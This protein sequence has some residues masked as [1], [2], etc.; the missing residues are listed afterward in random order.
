MRYAHVTMELPDR[1]SVLDIDWLMRTQAAQTGQTLRNVVG[2]AADV[3]GGPVT[4]IAEALHDL[5]WQ[6][7][8]M[9]QWIDLRH[10]LAHALA[11]G[12]WGPAPTGDRT[13]HSCSQWLFPV[14]REFARRQGRHENGADERKITCVAPPL[15]DLATLR[16]APPVDR[17]WVSPHYDIWGCG[18]SPD[19]RY[20]VSGSRGGQGGHLIVWDAEHGTKTAHVL[21]ADEVR[22]CAVT[23]D[24]RYVISQNCRGN[25]S[26][27]TLPALTL[28]GTIEQR[29]EQADPDEELAYKPGHARGSPRRWRR[30]AISPDARQLA[31]AMR[32]H[33]RIYTL[34]PFEMTASVNDLW[35]FPHGIVALGFVG[36][37][38][39]VIVGRNEP[40]PVR[41]CDVKSGRVVERR[42]FEVPPIEGITRAIVL[43]EQRLV[44]AGG[45]RAMVVWRLD[46]ASPVAMTP[47]PIAGQG[48]A[49]SADGTM[50]A[51]S[52]AVEYE[53][54][55]VSNLRDEWIRLWS[56]PDLREL[57][58]WRVADLGCREIVTALA[59]SPDNRHLIVGGW[60]G[61][62][63]R[64]VLSR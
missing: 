38:H 18:V 20:V 27:W 58:S 3:Y 52:G 62:L 57:M 60:E 56:L 33:V 28:I 63:R 14:Y 13:S 32:D 35:H 9:L 49:V 37:D 34:A 11:T 8:A 45:Y 41:V 12:S 25:V 47:C 4:A 42:N 6:A 43:S 17:A 48:L 10:G 64:L 40:M 1:D 30:F 61:V 26:V 5:S 23:P 50:A 54:V 51:T 15:P 59:F 21:D 44:V 53:T 36:V 29:P 7:P 19:G 31:V 24:D 16:L 46:G 55:R 39:L 22:D 2:D